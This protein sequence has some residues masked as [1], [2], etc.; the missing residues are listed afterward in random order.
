MTVGW[1]IPTDLGNTFIPPS[2]YQSSDIICHL[3]A[4]NA[5]IEAPVKAG[6]K[7]ELYWTPWPTSHHGPVVDYLANCHGPCET[8]DKTTLQWFKIDQVGLLNPAVTDVR[9]FCMLLGAA[10]VFR[11]KSSF[12]R[13]EQPSRCSTLRLLPRTLI[14]A[15]ANAATSRATGR[16]TS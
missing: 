3:A 14:C 15:N 2:S 12:T 7:V 9:N 16:L 4:T 10:L 6:Q 11:L 1:K 8:V 5:M 13:P